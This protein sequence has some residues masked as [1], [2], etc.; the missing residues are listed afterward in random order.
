MVEMNLEPETIK[1]NAL[2]SKEKSKV[3]K[4]EKN[5]GLLSKGKLKK[6]MTG[7]KSPNNHKRN[8]N[9]K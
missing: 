2:T 4:R 5:I 8:R 9:G 6:K 1:P 3:L 7:S